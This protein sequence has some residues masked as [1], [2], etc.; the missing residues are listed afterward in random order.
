MSSPIQDGQAML[1]QF[2]NEVLSV[3]RDSCKSE[4]IVDLCRC[5]FY[6]KQ[7]DVASRLLSLANQN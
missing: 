1:T 2:S 4:L 6:T 7:N 3:N 5:A